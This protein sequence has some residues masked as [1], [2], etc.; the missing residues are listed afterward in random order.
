MPN[1]IFVG[2]TEDLNDLLQDLETNQ[3]SIRLLIGDPDVGKTSLLNEYYYKVQ[4]KHKDNYFVGYYSKEISLIAEGS[5]YLYPFEKCLSSLITSI[6]KNQTTP[7]Q[8]K[9]F[10]KRIV[11]SLKSFAKETGKELAIAIA[12]DLI[13]KAGLEQSASVFKKYL[14]FYKKTRSS[15][16]TAESF[17]LDQQQEVFNLYIKIFETLSDEFPERCFLLIFDQFEYVGKASVNFLLNLINLLPKTFHF[18]IAFRTPDNN[19]EDLSIRRM[20]EN[21]HDKIVNDLNGKVLHLKGLTPEEIGEWISETRQIGLPLTP[22]LKRI[23]EKSGGLPLILE[24][25]IEKSDKLHYDEIEEGNYCQQ[26]TKIQ[27]ILSDEDKIRIRK[28]SILQYTTDQNFLTH[29][30]GLNKETLPLFLERVVSIG[31]F[32]QNKQWFKHELIQKCF[33]MILNEDL[34]TDYFR[35]ASNLVKR[36][37]FTEQIE[38]YD[39]ERY[40]LD[41]YYSYY[42]HNSKNY[43]ES[44]SENKKTAHNA[45]VLADLDH[46]ERCYRRALYATTKENNIPKDQIIKCLEDLTLNVLDVWGR[47]DEA[48]TNYSKIIDH[49]SDNNDKKGLAFALNYIG[50]IHDRKGQYDLALQKY[51]ES[52]EIKRKLGDEKGIGIT[53]NNIGLIH[54]KNRYYNEALQNYQESLE[55]RRKLGDQEGIAMNLFNI[56][57]VNDE[58]GN[59]N[60]ALQNY[61]TS[62]KIASNLGL[63][64]GIAHLL[65]NI[66]LIHFKRGEYDLALQNYQ[67]SLEIRRKLGDQANAAL[68]LYNIGLLHDK[69]GE[70]KEALKKYE[71]SLDIRKRLGNQRDIDQTL[72][73]IKE[74]R[75]KLNDPI[76]E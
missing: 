23:R 22:D 63:Q 57:S 54:F 72:N 1:N 68:T 30:L 5:S 41:L 6:K 44:F 10:S 25:W 39:D 42:L 32:D 65:N 27:R 66:G 33:E 18:V 51:Q 13:K 38:S 31:I 74:T 75:K 19:W 46:A 56:G 21:I 53:L 37:Y 58:T 11:D 17:L 67:E 14:H 62:W 76:P 29:Y 8:F 4:D 7:E 69:K 59:Y 9:I 16:S 52:L 43:K 36:F 2:R 50:T 26:I 73:K 15:T 64:V 47:Y 60:E 28:M 61:Q 24:K 12:E 20:Y 49:Y 71:K 3:K 35:L 48:L 34:K 45:I 70:Y 40:K 55:I